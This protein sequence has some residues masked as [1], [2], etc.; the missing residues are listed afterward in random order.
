MA[1]RSYLLKYNVHKIS[2][3]TITIFE[4][5]LCELGKEMRLK[6]R[7]IFLLINGCTAYKVHLNL[8]N[9]RVE[10]FLASCTSKLSFCDL[11]SYKNLNLTIENNLKTRGK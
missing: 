9:V 5:F 3:M 7:T 11:R 6:K 10:V 4:S 2:Y 8:K 1:L